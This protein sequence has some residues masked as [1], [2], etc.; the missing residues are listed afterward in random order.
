MALAQDPSVALARARHEADTAGV[1]VAHARL[2]PSVNFAASIGRSHTDTEYL[3]SSRPGLSDD[4]QSRNFT[5][6]ARQALYRP[7]DKAALTKAEG[8]AEASAHI[9]KLAEAELLLR[10]ARAYAQVLTAQAQREV[11]AN[12]VDRLGAALRQAEQGF[13]AGVATRT[14]VED[15]R[16][17]R[18]IA[19]AA[20][21]RAE[22]ELVR[23]HE[24]LQLLIGTD[25]PPQRLRPFITVEPL[26]QHVLAQPLERWQEQAIAHN[27]E[28]RALHAQLRA[29]DEE[30]RR[31]RAQHLP[32]LDLVASHRHTRSD[33]ETT[34]GQQ[35]DTT[36]IA[37]QFNLP[38][39]AGGGIDASV[40]VALAGRSEAEARLNARRRELTQGITQAYHGV[41]FGLAQWQALAQAERSAEQAL[42]GTRKGLE[43]GTRNTVDVLNAEQELARVRASRID[44]AYRIL[45]AAVE[46]LTL[47]EEEVDAV[48]RHLQ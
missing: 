1:D 19:T 39:Y 48:L 10:V 37:L 20:L 6:T 30:V 44:I 33:T 9:R 18:D 17:R 3:G 38:I 25:S 8:Q 12:E 24:A 35:Y 45:V 11:A 7:M 2:L 21:V 14:D 27:P 41:R 16:A 40:R 32:T 15:A 28:I 36:A 4:Y 26:A 5:L 43:A 42:I 22:G 34:I 47:A 29:A 46:V 23:A 31:Q 13:A